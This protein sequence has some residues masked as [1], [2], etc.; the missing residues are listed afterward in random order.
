M[1]KKTRFFAGFVTFAIVLSAIYMINP[2]GTPSKHAIARIVGYAPFRI[3]SGSMEPTLMPGDFIFA[4]SYAYRSAPPE[5]G[6]VVV[7]TFP[8]NPKMVFVKRVAAVG[9]DMLELKEQQLV[10]NGNVI[11]EPY[12]KTPKSKRRK[13]KPYSIEVPEGKH[14]LEISDGTS[15]GSFS[16]SGGKG[17]SRMCFEVAS[18]RVTTGKCK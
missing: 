5:R 3:P 10:I 11:S 6:D 16:I 4:N 13:R 8:H 9:G 17:P 1:T 15:S 2:S 14:S 7:F 18:G 12:L